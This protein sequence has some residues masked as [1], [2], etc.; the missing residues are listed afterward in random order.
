MSH[1]LLFVCTGNTCR[2]PLAEALARRL[3][4]ER[5]LDIRVASAGTGALYGS[6]ASDGSILVGLERALDLSAHRA[7][8]LSSALVDEA[9]LILCMSEHHVAQA[10]ALGGAGKVHLL[11]DFAAGVAT[12]R[13][14][15]DP[16]GSG[17]DAYRVMADELDELM[18]RVI[19]RLVREPL[20]PGQS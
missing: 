4:R 6:P 12:R 17:L 15:S 13:A 1:T 20:A 9:A 19:D 18:P 10:H 11:S 7:R 8:M 16:F 5:G 14:I 3:A 2:S